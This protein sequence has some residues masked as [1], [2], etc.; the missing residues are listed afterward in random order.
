MPVRIVT[1]SAADLDAAESKELGVEV[2][3]LSIR[4]GS[5]EYT[6]GVD[7]SVEQFY[8]KLSSSQELPETAAP[9]PGA[10]EAA[11]RRQAEAGADAVVCINLSSGLSATMQAAQNGA[12]ALEGELDVRVVD[13]RSITS[14][15]GSQVRRAAQ[16]AAGGADAD[17]VESLVRGLSSRTHVIGALD[18]LDNLRKGGRIGGA[19]AALGSLLAIKPLLDISTGEVEEA[20]RARTRR[21]ALHALRDKV[22][23]RTA[24]EDLT[25]AHGMAPDLDEMRE[26]LSPRYPADQ[27]RVT[28]I[29][30]TIGT[31]AGPR[32]MGVTWIDPG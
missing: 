23:E 30:A 29:G 9:S 4:F 5:T 18:T 24:V 13:S 21:K 7:L 15:L 31:H 2:V 16:A 25:L 1:D 20:G 26:L 8:D 27:I 14:G 19:Q 17:A 28:T 10:F 11:F 22:F 12:K 6:D 3:P 32:V